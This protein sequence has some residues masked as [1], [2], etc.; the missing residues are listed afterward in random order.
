MGVPMEGGIGEMVRSGQ[1]LDRALLKSSLQRH[2]SGVSILPA[3]QHPSEWQAISPVHIQEIVDEMARCFDFVILDTPGT[4]NDLVEEA[5]QTA[6]MILLL[7]STDMA[8]IK[9]TVLTLD[10]L[11]SWGFSEDKVKLA[12]NYANPVN[13][14]G[15]A[16]LERTL[17][18]KVF[19]SIPYDKAVG[20]S[21]QAGQPL[22]IADPGS[23]VS[24]NFVKLARSLCGAQEPSGRSRRA[25]RGFWRQAR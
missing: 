10:M 8:S 19:W 1:P 24:R 20:V 21:T 16:D 12:V 6:T 18:H 25:V 7:T 11:R 13:R 3:P 15:V 14:I 4:F 22:V 5:L 9:D 2:P 23:R 17:G